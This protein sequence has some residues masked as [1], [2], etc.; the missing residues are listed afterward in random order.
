MKALNVSFLIGR[1]CDMC[2]DMAPR[3]EYQRG[4]AR[5]CQY[6]CGSSRSNAADF[7]CC[8]FSDS[9]MGFAEC[10]DD[11]L[12]R[13][14]GTSIL[15]KSGSESSLSEDD[16]MKQSGKK[17]VE[18]QGEEKEACSDEEKNK[19]NVAEESQDKETGKGDFH[20]QQAVRA[21]STDT[22]DSPQQSPVVMRR[23]SS[24]RIN[25]AFR[26]SEGSRLLV[27][28][29]DVNHQ[30]SRAESEGGPGGES[31][32]NDGVSPATG[33]DDGSGGRMRASKSDTS[34]TDSFVMVG[35][36]DVADIVSS[37]MTSRNKEDSVGWRKRR[38]PQNILREGFKW[39]RQLVFRS[40]LTMHTAY[41]R[42]DNAEPASITALAV[43][44]DHRTVYVGDTRGRVFS[45]SVSDQPGR[46][47]A[48]HWLKDEG[49]DTCVGCGVRF[50]LYERRH[51][52]RNCGQVFCSKM[53]LSFFVDVA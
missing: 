46:A 41:D 48:D 33:T 1:Y 51:H 35:E 53:N 3:M 31:V 9:R 23:K 38:N 4:R 24:T 32:D 18:S 39:Q 27:G 8:I 2:W 37:N 5:K 42:K 52:C 49:A 7:V 44:R 26:K 16:E 22:Q 29:V 28:S 30:R 17:E 47:V 45:W 50:T 43:S 6:L 10:R 20:R 15:T 12:D 34:L 36:A 25:P 19:E 14:S 11:W 21:S 13:R 40:K